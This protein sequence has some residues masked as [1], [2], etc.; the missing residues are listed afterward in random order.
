MTSGAWDLIRSAIATKLDASAGC[1]AAGLRRATANM[2]LPLSML[3]ELRVLNPDFTPD[4]QTGVTDAY[5]LVIPFEIVVGQPTGPGRSN[6]IAA[7]I[8]RAVQ[9]EWQSGYKLTSLNLGLV[10]I[11]DGRLDPMTT[12]LV[13]YADLTN[14]AGEPLGLDGYHGAITVQVQESV[15]RTA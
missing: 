1:T 7:D 3:P 6:P 11:V 14:A 13:E 10:S 4:W 5:T 2:D 12:G 15:T 9:V 8:A